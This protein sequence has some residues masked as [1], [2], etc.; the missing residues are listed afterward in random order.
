M[1]DTAQQNQAI[2]IGLRILPI[3][4]GETRWTRQKANAFVVANRLGLDSCQ[5]RDLA[6]SEMLFPVILTGCLLYLHIPVY[7][8]F[9]QKLYTFQSLE[10]QDLSSALF[11]HRY[12]HDV[13]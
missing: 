5:A 11:A 10:G 8:S 2:D 13:H 9:C 6:D 1:P 7:T 4:V 12:L 3:T